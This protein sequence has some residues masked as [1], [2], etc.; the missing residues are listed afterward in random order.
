MSKNMFQA[1]QEA[2]QAIEG[3]CGPYSS[4]FK[5]LASSE[6]CYGNLQQ[7]LQTV[8]PVLDSLGA[9]IKAVGIT[10]T[11]L[12]RGLETFGQKLSDARI[13]AGNPMLEMEVSNKF[14]ENT[15][16]QLQLQEIL[17]EVESLRKQLANKSSE[18]QHLQHA[19]T[20]SV[21]NEQASKSQNSRLEIEKTALQGELQLL[22]QRIREELGAAGIKLQGEMRAKFEQQVQGLETEKAKLERDFKTLQTELAT[23][24]SSLVS[25]IVLDQTVVH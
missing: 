12:V 4:I 7:R 16:L 3:N 20:E 15:Q 1:L 21:T 6:S 13:P 11:D 19:L 2:V 9:S 24:Q 22:E 5:Q 17:T 23:T 10:E 25:A 18:N 8:E 14:A